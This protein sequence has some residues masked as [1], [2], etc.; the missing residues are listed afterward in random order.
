MNASS[1][2]TSAPIIGSVSHPNGG[3]DFC[4]FFNLRVISACCSG[5]DEIEFTRGVLN[6]SV[7]LSGVTVRVKPVEEKSVQVSVVRLAARDCNTVREH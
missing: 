4:V 6:C 2:I 7:V 3:R 1:M 5:Q